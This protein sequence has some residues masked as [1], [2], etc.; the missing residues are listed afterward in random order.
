[1]NPAVSVTWMP[2]CQ[3]FDLPVQSQFVGRALPAISHARAG[4]AH[5]AAD[6]PLGYP[7]FLVEVVRGGPLLVRGHHFF[8]CDVLEHRFVQEQFGHQPLKAVD[9]ELQL[10]APAIGIDLARCM[11]LSPTIIGRLGDA[12]LATDVRGGQSFGQIAVGV[13][14]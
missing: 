4:P 6:S 13:T 7:V 12:L 11:S 2:P 1:V 8:F 10:A 14:E 3:A 5:D 9:L